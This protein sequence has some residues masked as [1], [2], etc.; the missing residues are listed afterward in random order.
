MLPLGATQPTRLPFA[1]PVAGG[2]F[3]DPA[4]SPDGSRIAFVVAWTTEWIGQV[5]GDL[6]VA[7]RDGTG[8]TRLTTAEGLDDQPA[9]SPDGRKIA[10]RSVRDAGRS[11]VWVMNA[12]GT[13][14]T[15]LTPR[16]PES[17]PTVVASAGPSWSP[18]GARIAY[19]S[20]VL[21][22]GD[23]RVWTMSADGSDKRQVT[24]GSSLDGET[25][26]EPTWSPD[27]TRI[28]FRRMNPY[29][30]GSDIAV[31]ELIGIT[32]GR[33]TRLALTGEQ[34][35]PAW[36]PDGWLLAFTSTHDGYTAEIYTA[37]PDGRRV[38]RR[39]TNGEGRTPAWIRAATPAARRSPTTEK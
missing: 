39:T 12:D 28:A 24:S 13:A 30:F 31:V 15:N 34:T 19:S 10:F 32:G 1:V 8:M 3:M 17:P 18:D 29:T 22:R 4:P 35:S 2:Y 9:W 33:V 25:D 26:G 7:N 27:G 20:G 21:G 6:W 14:Q 16:G 38:V 36:S 11:Q 37:R 5:D 23:H